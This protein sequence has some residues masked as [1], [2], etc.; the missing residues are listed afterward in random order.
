MT[1]NITE[2]TEIK[3]EQELIKP[4]ID[5]LY[6]TT[7]CDNSKDDYKNIIN[8]TNI[9]SSIIEKGFTAALSTGDFGIKLPKI[10]IVHKKI[11]MNQWIERIH[12]VLPGVKI[13]IVKGNKCEIE[14]LSPTAFDDIGHVII[15][16]C[17]K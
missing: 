11:L 15:D 10:L 1:E 4:S 7:Y 5:A 14:D 13:G 16:E 8:Q 12:F 17:H 2:N 3:T 6:P 9:K